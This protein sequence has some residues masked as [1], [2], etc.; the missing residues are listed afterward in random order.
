MINHYNEVLRRTANKK[1][2]VCAH[3]P[4]RPTGLQRTWPNFMACEA[5]R[6]MEF[7]AWSKGNDPES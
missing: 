3:E 2:M 5:A 1:I 7:N 4:V 6:G